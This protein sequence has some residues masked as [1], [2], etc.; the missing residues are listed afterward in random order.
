VAP[1][2]FPPASDLAGRAA[3]VAAAGFLIAN[4]FYEA[5]VMHVAEGT[6][7]LAQEQ[8][9]FL[10]SQ[11]LLNP[12]GVLI[13]GVSLGAS[14]FQ[15]MASAGTAFVWSPRSNLELYGVT[16]NIGAALDAGV[17]IALAPDWAVTGSGN[18][19]DELKV[20]ARWNRE[21]LGGRL[22]DRQLVEM[23][24][25]AA[26]RAVGVHDEVGTLA[27]GLRADLL[28]V[29]GDLNDPFGAV[30]GAS[31]ADVQLVMIGGVPLYGARGLMAPF[32]SQGD[33]EKIA[34]PGASKVLASPAAAIVVSQVAARL[35]A[36]LLA[37][38]TSLAP[39][40][41]QAAR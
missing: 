37:Q 38:G 35:T 32:W 21:K 30:V 14:D 18:M 33:L 7:A 15:A 5:L 16:A 1:A 9:T 22:T 28:V 19:L 40:T 12:K 2:E 31:A 36:A 6:D 34:L 25:S 8:F 3:F 27:P 23:A 13:H 41:E 29:S 10:Q 11:G 26:A 39:L 24:T 17:E 20:A 4:P